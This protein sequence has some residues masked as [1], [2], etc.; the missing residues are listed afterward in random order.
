VAQQDQ[1]RQAEQIRRQQNEQMQK[2]LMHHRLQVGC[3]VCARA[4]V[5][6]ANIFFVAQAAGIAEGVHARGAVFKEALAAMPINMIADAELLELIQMSAS[7]SADGN[8]C[9]LIDL[10]D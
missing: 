4:I 1:Q 7:S 2:N 10:I 9:R 3:G 5:A 6:N 8:V